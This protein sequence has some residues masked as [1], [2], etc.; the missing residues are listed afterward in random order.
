M[1]RETHCSH[2][3]T[4]S[5]RT[6]TQHRL[7]RRCLGVALILVAACRPSAIYHVF[8][9]VTNQTWQRTDTLVFELPTPTDSTLWQVGVGVRCTN[10]LRYQDLWM[11]VE[12]RSD[13]VRRDTVHLLLMNGRG[14]WLEPSTILHSADRP[15]MALRL[16]KPG[17]KLLVYHV[18][19]PF[20]VEGISEVGIKLEPATSAL[21]PVAPRIDTQQDE[22]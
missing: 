6:H 22:Q 21:L 20:S 3:T 15:V 7:L 17:T 1:R 19:R 2:V 10:Q 12:E 13:T 5:G 4:P 14:E 11:V 8:Q 9:P 16:T 18:M